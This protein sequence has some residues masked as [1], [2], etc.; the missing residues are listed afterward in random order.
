M[1]RNTIILLFCFF[2]QLSAD[3]QGNKGYG[4][5]YFGEFVNGFIQIIQLKRMRFLAG[6]ESDNQII[7]IAFDIVTIFFKLEKTK[8]GFGISSILKKQKTGNN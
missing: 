3:G 4:Y 2:A 6:I 5:D 1:I 8:Q 7:P